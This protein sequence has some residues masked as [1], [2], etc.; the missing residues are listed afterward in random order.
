MTCDGDYPV[1]YRSVRDYKRI[2]KQCGLT[3][4]GVEKNEPYVLMQ[5]GCELIRKWKR[6]VPESFQLLPVVGRLTYGAMRLTAPWIKRL[7][8]LLGIEFPSLEN[9]FF[10]LGT[11]PIAN[12]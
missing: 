6:I 8:K 9:H 12:K 5:M 11:R 10:T 1:V 3:L 4:K 7:P 2:F